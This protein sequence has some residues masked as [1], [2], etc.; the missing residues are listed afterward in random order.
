M[1]VTTNNDTCSFIRKFG[2]LDLQQALTIETP[3]HMYLKE[4]GILIDAEEGLIHHHST[5][6][7][8]VEMLEISSTKVQACRDHSIQEHDLYRFDG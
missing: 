2:L 5:S 3:L 6:Y 1:H 4:H 7:R 8:I